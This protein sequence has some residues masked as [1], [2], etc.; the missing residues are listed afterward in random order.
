VVRAFQKQRKADHEMLEQL[1]GFFAFLRA[2]FASTRLPASPGETKTSLGQLLEQTN[3]YI[4][5]EKI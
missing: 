3:Q 5:T 1:G 4:E 2:E